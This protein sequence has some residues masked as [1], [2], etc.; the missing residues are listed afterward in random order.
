VL[1]HLLRQNRH[2]RQCKAHQDLVIVQKRLRQQRLAAAK[3]VSV[4]LTATNSVPPPSKTAPPQN[5]CHVIA[6]ASLDESS[7]QV[8]TGIDGSN[9]DGVIVKDDAINLNDSGSVTV[10][11]EQ[12]GG[13]HPFTLWS[14]YDSKEAAFTTCRFT[15]GNIDYIGNIETTNG[16]NTYSN[17]GIYL[18]C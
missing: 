5:W 4:S 3:V 1:G 13:P 8:K 12:L 9:K 11:P 7:G 2:L 10:Q 6:Y 17:C 16:V 14:T 15:Y 18:A